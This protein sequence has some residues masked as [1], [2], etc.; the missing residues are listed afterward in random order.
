MP[1]IV[2]ILSFHGWIGFSDTKHEY[3][4]SR[5]V[6]QCENI[7]ELRNADSAQANV[8]LPKDLSELQAQCGPKLEDCMR[9]PLN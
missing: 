5:S 7:A 8:Y 6:V 9:S 2:C 4:I 1:I 3:Y